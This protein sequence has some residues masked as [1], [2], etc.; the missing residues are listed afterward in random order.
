[1]SGV[2]G[3]LLVKIVPICRGNGQ[4]AERVCRHRERRDT[5]GRDALR[6]QDLPRLGVAPSG[7]LPRQT[8]TRRFRFRATPA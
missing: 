2:Y 7:D 3:R 6:R 1:M 8:K 4:L 5:S